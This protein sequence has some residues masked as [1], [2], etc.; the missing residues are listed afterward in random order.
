M[1]EPLQ[2]PRVTALLGPTN[3]GKTHHAVT[4][5]LAHQ[6][7]MTGFPL[8]LLA[9]ENYDRACAEK[10]ADRVALITGEE[11][12]VPPGARY[13]MCTAESM[14]LDR[15][16]EFLAIDEIQTAADPERGHVFTERLLSARGARETMLLGAD[17]MRRLIKALVPEAEIETRPRFSKLRHTGP[18]KVHR[19]KPRSAVIAF[20]AADVYAIAELVRRHRGG[21]A[22]VLGALSPR[23]RNAQAAMYQA[24]EVDFLIATDAIGMG[25]NMD[26]RHAAFAQTH[27]FDGRA[28][29]NLNPAELAQIAGRAG[30]HVH[31]GTFGATADAKPFDDETVARI[32]NHDF[33]SLRQIFWRNPDLSFDS[34]DALNAALRAPPP[35]PGLRRV[36]E[37][38]DERALTALTGGDET[39]KHLADAPERVAL[40]WRVCQIP[41]FRG[42][43]DDGHT[44][45][46]RRIYLMLLGCDPETP[47]GEPGRIPEAFIRAQVGRI[48]RADG[49]IH[50][51]SARIAAI[52]TWTY[53]AHHADWLED[54]EAW[55]AETRAVEDKLS[56]ALHERLRLR[57]VDKRTAALVSGLNDDRRD[58]AAAVRADGAVLVEGHPVGVIEGLRFSPADAETG[59]GRRAVRAAAERILAGALAERAARIIDDPDK[60]FTIGESLT[61]LWQ[62]DP[63]AR[64]GRGRD[65][66][67]PALSLL[68]DEVLP[69]P[70]RDAVTA[71]LNAWLKA[72]IAEVFAP[73]LHNGAD[74]SGPARGVL[75]QAR[76]GLG[77]VRRKNAAAMIADLDPDA[78]RSLRQAGVIVGRE[79]VYAPALLK[80]AARRW[81]AALHALWTG[82]PEIGPIPDPG[83]GSFA[84]D[85]THDPARL[86]KLGYR[87]LG[88]RAV[89]ADILERLAEAAWN[90]SRSGAF[91]PTVEMVTML[92]AGAEA[93]ALVLTALGYRKTTAPEKS[94][95]SE[96]KEALW[97][98]RGKATFKPRTAPPAAKRRPAKPDPDSP[99]AA[100]EGLFNQAGPQA[101]GE[102]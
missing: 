74:L 76:E 83:L 64:L 52:R 18:A 12:I 70:A 61:V 79:S 23:T 95:D 75:F 31:D 99:F 44:A 97:L 29:R 47:G 56:D 45:L 39:V 65:M 63:L 9:R 87:V 48:D 51:L 6:S 62:G 26:I 91:K 17:T 37:A 90:A 72:Q 82:A 38:D 22:V 20:S 2:P 92:G 94:A 10:G 96:D 59:A 30:R 86:E 42:M 43:M 15:R 66:Y 4:R 41:D 13:F 84:A 32:E 81:R 5:M 69:A 35:H 50:T 33:E 93:G 14:P 49:D 77:G 36:R 98:K 102:K 85:K 3:T 40:L 34:I 101:S 8:R 21:A 11:K 58:L 19:L 78:R 1:A 55:R 100:L 67:G 60:A 53:I 88:G 89:R 54:A 57:F 7:G 46:L 24:G 28:R 68:A 25:L 71:R 73:V 16:V 27:K 80:P